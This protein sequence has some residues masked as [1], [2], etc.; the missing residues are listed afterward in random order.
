[1]VRPLSG[2]AI[3]LRSDVSLFRKSKQLLSF[4]LQAG[5]CHAIFCRSGFDCIFV[6]QL[7]QVF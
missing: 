1:L 3:R 5:L 2:S 6:C 4:L 7:P